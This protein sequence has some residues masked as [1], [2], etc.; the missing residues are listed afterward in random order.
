MAPT[1]KELTTKKNRSTAKPFY[2]NAA[3][4]SKGESKH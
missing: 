4:D 2:I 1:Q 3:L